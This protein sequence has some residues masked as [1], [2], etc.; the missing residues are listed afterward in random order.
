[1][2]DGGAIILSVAKYYSPGGKA[3]QDT[4]VTPTVVVAEAE[5]VAEL[6]EEAP[7][8]TPPAPERPGEDLILKKALEVA[9]QGVPAAKPPQR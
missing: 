2:D 8:E 9:I 7:P 1:M 3:I 4:G 6:D 5:P